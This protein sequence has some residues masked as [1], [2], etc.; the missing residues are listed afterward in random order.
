MKSL[1][2]LPTSVDT[3]EGIVLIKIESY[4]KTLRFDL[5][6]FNLPDNIRNFIKENN[7]YALV[8]FQRWWNLTTNDGCYAVQ[9]SSARDG[10]IY[11]KLVFCI[12]LI[13]TKYRSERCTEI[14]NK[15]ISVSE[16][17]FI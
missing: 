1:K 7:K 3:T 15:R 10:F 12:E 11:F 4:E 2:M 6:K 17:A 16:S 8:V 5:H 13:H 9:D 14:F